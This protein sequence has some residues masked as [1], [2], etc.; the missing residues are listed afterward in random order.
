MSIGTG[1]KGFGRYGIRAYDMELPNLSVNQIGFDIIEI[2]STFISTDKELV[3]SGEYYW[4]LIKN[5]SNGVD[6]ANMQ[7]RSVVGD[8]LT[9]SATGY[10]TTLAN[11]IELTADGQVIGCFDKVTVDRPTSGTTVLKLIRGAPR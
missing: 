4:I 2:P 6:A 11:M 9:K 1:I 8:D 10:D 3:P 5:C 7:A